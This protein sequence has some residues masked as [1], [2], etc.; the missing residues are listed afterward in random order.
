[1]NKSDNARIRFDQGMN[2]TQA[3]LT[4]FAADFG[5][6]EEIAIKIA[7][8]FGGGL[9]RSGETCGA[10]TG[11]LMVLGLQYGANSHTDPA[12]KQDTYAMGQEFLQQFRARNGALDCRDLLG[13]DISTSEGQQQA[14]EQGV[15]RTRCPLLV[16]S[17][18]EIVEE[19][20]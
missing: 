6:D 20:I 1:M 10:A 15:F 2:C 13:H 9:S 4:A 18:A 5:L 16:Q 3:V 11:A 8:A 19:L 12:A 14:R 7:C 17:A